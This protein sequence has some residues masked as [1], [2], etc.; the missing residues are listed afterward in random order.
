MEH[1]PEPVRLSMVTNFY[2]RA[3]EEKR[4]VVLTYKGNELPQGIAV[5]D[6]ERGGANEILQMPWLSDTSVGRNF[7]FYDAGDANSFSTTELVQILA[8]IVSKNG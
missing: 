2:N 7:W 1:I 6:F 4:E 3:A 8:D 5:L